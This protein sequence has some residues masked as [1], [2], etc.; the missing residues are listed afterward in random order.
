MSKLKGPD[1]REALKALLDLL[2]DDLEKARQN[3]SGTVAQLAA[4]YRATLA[5]IAALD[6]ASPPAE[7]SALDEITARRTARDGAS[8]DRLRTAGRRKSG[9]G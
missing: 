7:V 8:A 9:N 6:A 5:D 4:Q 2:A 3:G 1:R